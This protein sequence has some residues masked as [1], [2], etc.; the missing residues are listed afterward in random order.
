MSLTNLLPTFLR[1]KP[2]ERELRIVELQEGLE[3]SEDKKTIRYNDSPD[4]DEV[5]AMLIEQYCSRAPNK[6]IVPQTAGLY[7]KKQEDGRYILADGGL[8]EVKNGK[9]TAHCN[10]TP[11]YPT[12]NEGTYKHTNVVT[13]D[14]KLS[15]K[16][17][18]GFGKNEKVQFSFMGSVP[19]SKYDHSEESNDLFDGIE[20]IGYLMANKESLTVGNNGVFRRVGEF[21]QVYLTAPVVEVQPLD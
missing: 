7:V 16:V 21:P 18:N 13:L 8:I 3:L 20:H 5:H 14:G 11:G 2:S 1:E 15:T 17:V 6:V 12:H 19:T 10:M 4:N 9:V